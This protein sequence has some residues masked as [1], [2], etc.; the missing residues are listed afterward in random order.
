VTPL[1]ALIEALEAAG[2]YDPDVQARP[3]AVVWCDPD[4]S[5]GPV[6]PMLR[7]RLPRLHSLGDLDP[8]TLTAPAFA[9]RLVTA[10]AEA[11]GEFPP[12]LWLPHVSR[13]TLRAAGTCPELLQPLAWLAVAGAF[14]GHVNGKDWSLRAFLTAERGPLRLSIADG[15]DAK[16]A[17]ALAAPHLFARPIESL[18][19][20]FD[21]EALHALCAPDVVADMLEWIEGRLSPEVDAARFKAFAVRAAK[22]LGFDPRKRPPDEAARLLAGAADGWGPVWN[23][24]QAGTGEGYSHV[25]GALKGADAPGGLFEQNANFPAVNE[26]AEAQLRAELLG[27]SSLSAPKAAERIAELEAAHGFRRDSIWARR[28]EAPLACALAGLAGVASAPAWPH[29]DAASLAKHYVQHGAAVDGAA[30]RALASAPGETERAAVTAALQAVYRPWVEEGCNA[31]QALSARGEVPFGNVELPATDISAVVFVDGLRFDLAQRLV[32]RLE[33]LGARALLGWRWSGFPTTTAC[34]KPLVS[35]VADLLSGAG[36]VE[37]ALP[38]SGDG[39]VADHA[40]LRRL[41]KERGFAFE[42]EASGRLWIETGNFDED[43][44]KL[45]ARLASQIGQGIEDAA[46]CILHLALAGRR[47]RVVTDH[48]WLLMPGGLPKAELGAGLSQPDEKRTRYARLKPGATTN[49]GQAAWSWNP[50]VRLAMAPGLSSF[51]AGYE[52][53]HGGVS[54]QECVIPV[55]DVEPLAAARAVEIAN[56]EWRGLRIRVEASGAGDLRFDLR[57][58]NDVSGEG[59]LPEPRRL[60]EEGKGSAPVPDDY[61]GQAAV[62]VVLSDDGRILARTSV[63]VGG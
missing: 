7:A 39:K 34:C 8:A 5:F 33:A 46:Q 36:G 32:G 14:F 11:A 31:L 13:E 29:T 52:Y 45:G 12:I 20:H 19:R 63:T 47:V 54:P 9:L 25:I 21:A 42:E 40:T 35:P 41:M 62:L 16:E 6:M 24:F 17:L 55:I 57:M 10:Q 26:R 30:L 60:D 22:E 44:H 53:A 27:L 50:D 4:A 56:V 15:A 28:G 59:L 3:E 51:Y 61:V 48:G 37:D 43:G 38:R 2:R 23:R 18:A 1:D 49:H 58:P